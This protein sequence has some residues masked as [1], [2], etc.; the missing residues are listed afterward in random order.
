MGA[1]EEGWP[2][3]EPVSAERSKT[4]REAGVS[5]DVLYQFPVDGPWSLKQLDELAQGDLDLLLGTIRQIPFED[6]WSNEQ[7]VKLS[8]TDLRSVPDLVRAH[9]TEG[10][11]T[12][13]EILT[14][15]EA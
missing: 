8:K 5:P 2:V 9:A 7:V 11:V 6:P 10:P 15:V 3:D 13:R 4:L 1:E 14:I 12:P